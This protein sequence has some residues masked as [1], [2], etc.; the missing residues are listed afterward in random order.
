MDKPLRIP[1]KKY[2]IVT[3]YCKAQT[4]DFANKV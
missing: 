3:S 1:D 2:I 4:L